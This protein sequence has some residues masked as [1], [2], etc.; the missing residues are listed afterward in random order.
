[1]IQEIFRSL[2]LRIADD[3]FRRS[4]LDDLTVIHEDDMIGDLSGKR[5]LM[6]H[7]DHRTI[8]FG[9]LTD[10]V[11]YFLGELRIQGTGR[12]IEA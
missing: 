8:L 3:F 2:I 11:Q 10:D 4:F 7:N 12:L 6:G 9:E 5:N 1:M